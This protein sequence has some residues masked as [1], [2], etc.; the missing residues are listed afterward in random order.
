MEGFLRE[1]FDATVTDLANW[2][3]P[4]WAVLER[5]RIIF[6]PPPSN[7]A[8]QAAKLSPRTPI[9]LQMVQHVA[10]A[11]T[12]HLGKDST[13]FTLH[14]SS[15]VSIT[16]Q[17]ATSAEKDAW[18]N[19]LCVGEQTSVAPIPNTIKQAMLACIAFVEQH[20]AEKA[21]FHRS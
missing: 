9:D 6:P 18:V 1:R 19:S 13:E 21:A 8:A 15:D 7:L 5:T 10:S 20:G 11:V 4:R 12:D 2:R 3:E 17:C 14:F 16:F